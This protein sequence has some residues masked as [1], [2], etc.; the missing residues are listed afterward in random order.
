MPLAIAD[1][2]ADAG[3][4]QGVCGS[5][6]L[7]TKQGTKR[8]KVSD[9]DT[10]EKA[11]RVQVLNVPHEVARKCGIEGM[12]CGALKAA[13]LCDYE[14]KG[15]P[16]INYCREVC[17]EDDSVLKCNANGDCCDKK[18]EHAAACSAYAGG[19]QCWVAKTYGED[20]TWREAV[21]AL[22]NCRY[23]CEIC[24][25]SL[26]EEA[27]MEHTK[28]ETEQLQVSEEVKDQRAANV[29]YEVARRCGIEGM[30]C[31]ELKEANLCDYSCRGT[32]VINYC[33]EV[34]E[35][36]DSVPN[37]NADG[38]CCDGTPRHV[39]ACSAYEGSVC[40]SAQRYKRRSR[41]NKVIDALDNCKYTCNVCRYR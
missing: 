1:V 32:P 9:E 25:A 33:R 34:C 8:L 3:E 39:S 10:D 2:C 14:C 17:E 29:P 37:C 15:D 19:P 11:D 35:R 22:E 41:W 40:T 5:S 36:D 20:A 27:S 30:S 38:S 16:I 7:Q 12:T 4:D 18:P 24:P 26:V 23:S 28:Q 31:G 21:D 6:M 13:N